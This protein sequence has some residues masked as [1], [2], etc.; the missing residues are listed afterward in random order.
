MLVLAII[1]SYVL[2]WANEAFHVE[3]DP[4]IEAITAALPGVNCG[5]CG[6]LGC[7]DF[8]A[9]IVEKG[10]APNK[11]PVGGSGTNQ[12][13]CEIMGLDA[14]DSVPMKA[15]IRCIAHSKDSK[16]TDYI[17]EQTCLGANFISGIKD[18]SY[19]CLGF[20]DCVKS[21]NYD[22]LNIQDGL[23]VVQYDSCVG[24]T[25]CTK[26]CPRSLITMIPFIS[27]PMPVVACANSD[28]AK[29]VKSACSKGCIACKM[30]ERK[31]D[32][33]MMSNNLVTINYEAYT[34]DRLSDTM[35]AMGKCPNQT[36]HL[37]GD[38]TKAPIIPSE[39]NSEVV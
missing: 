35:I 18:C 23:A 28:T 3:I 21:C 13:I 27:D 17:G 1:L 7:G 9:A 36:I 26:V 31:C 4:R 19:G 16:K 14:V 32:L 29:E 33:Y 38:I 22:A 2:G 20:G 24:C 6:F 37:V 39:A 34:A 12:S 15:M 11:C 25:V 5:G 30:C 8:A 10:E